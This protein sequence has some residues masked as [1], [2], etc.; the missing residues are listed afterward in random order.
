METSTIR[1]IIEQF[2][3][4][5]NEYIIAGFYSIL[6]TISIFLT[7]YISNYIKNNAK[8]IMKKIYIIIK[9]EQHDPT[10]NN[11][12][13]NND[14]NIYTQLVELR[15]KMD[16]DRTFLYRFH[17]GTSFAL[18][19]PMWKLTC[20]HETVKK[21]IS[22]EISKC[23]N[24][25]SS[26]IVNLL[27]VFWNDDHLE[28]GIVKIS[29]EGCT[30]NNIKKCLFPKGVFLCETNKMVDHYS[31]SF[32]ID[33]GIEYLILSPLIFEGNRIGFI[34]AVYCHKEKQIEEIKKSAESICNAGRE[35]VFSMVRGEQAIKEV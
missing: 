31:K 28:D 25:L 24:I 21:G 13:M 20:T 1:S 2:I 32:L 8:K 27:S 9:G 26:W 35:I 19:Q 10:P 30:C 6:G 33:Q 11:A 7:K 4:Y 12:L 14:L 5:H 22:S 18:N 34:G 17:N 15:I 16:A 29:P 3:N 23:R